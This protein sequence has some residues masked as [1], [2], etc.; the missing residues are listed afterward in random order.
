V[1]HVSGAS[2]QFVS[3]TGAVAASAVTDGHGSATLHLGALPTGTYTCR[4]LAPHTSADPVGPSLASTHPVPDRIFRPVTLNVSL[5][6]G[7]FAGV[8]PTNPRHATV[9]ASGDRLTV[10]VQ[11]VWMRSSAHSGR[12]G[13]VDMIVVH[14]TGCA[15]GPAVN[16]FLAE[17]GPHYM[18]DTDGQ[19]VKWVQD[20]QAAWHAG[21]ARWGGRTSINGCSIGIE[22]VHSSGSYPA[23]QYTALLGL[24]QRIRHAFAA[25]H[26]W[27]VVGHSDV[28]TNSHG[29]LGRK[30]GDPGLTFEWA[31]LESVGLGMRIA[32]GPP[33]VGIYSGF[34]RDFPHDSL[35]RGDND[36][37]HRF[38]GAHRPTITGTPI[39]ELQQ[40]LSSIGYSVGTPDGDFGDLTHHAV[41]A[42]QEHFFAGS[43][44]HESPDGRVDFPTAG[45]VKSVAA[46]RA[47]V[48]SPVAV[49]AS[50]P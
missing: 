28:G 33:W 49:P 42:F 3:P 9:A 46:A 2:V 39:H 47:S 45:L 43:R 29:R 15:L 41:L 24:L 37:H 35:R 11:P 5:T 16:T 10:D 14:H 4:V 20:S 48:L 18:I 38:G 6:P 22:I 12:S 44:G 27:D 13:S 50:G 8:V 30:S 17:K 36:L 26:A 7:G 34:F 31:R 21:V 23:A 40:D 19:I 32:A 25:I 1:E